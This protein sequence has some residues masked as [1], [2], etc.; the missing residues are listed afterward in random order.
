MNCDQLKIK[1]FLLM[2]ISNYSICCND[3]FVMYDIEFQQNITGEHFVQMRMRPTVCSL[4]DT[5]ESSLTTEAFLRRYYK[6]AG[7]KY[8]Y[9]KVVFLYTSKRFGKVWHEKEENENCQR[10]S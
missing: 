9:V 8:M 2:L 4:K 3:P 6:R 1:R 10:R 5:T 7:M